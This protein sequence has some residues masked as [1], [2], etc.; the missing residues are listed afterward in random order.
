[1]PKTR[2]TVRTNSRAPRGGHTALW[3]YG[4]DEL[5]VLFGFRSAGSV[6][7]AVSRKAFDPTDLLSI[8]AFLQ[9]RMARRKDP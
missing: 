2:R 4:Y 1:M 9:K 5:R 6:R 3:G 8:F 7:N